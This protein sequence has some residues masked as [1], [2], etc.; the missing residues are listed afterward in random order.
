MKPVNNRQGGDQYREMFKVGFLSVFPQIRDFRSGTLD[1]RL[2]HLYESLRCGLYHTS[3][4]GR[5][6]GLEKTGKA[7]TILR[8]FPSSFN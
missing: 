4:P 5:G 8:P 2:N 3:M 6:V 7:I 1:K